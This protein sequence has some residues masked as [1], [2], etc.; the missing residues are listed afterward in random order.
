[1]IPAS[2]LWAIAGACVVKFLEGVIDFKK[3]GEETWSK[4]T[5]LVRR[6]RERDHL[7][8]YILAE[9]IET[10]ILLAIESAKSEV[11]AAER[12]IAETEL[13][14]ALVHFGIESQTAARHASRIADVILQSLAQARR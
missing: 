4:L 13:K 9:P 11:S 7:E 3:L 14:K 12:S 2:V 5:E 10:P 6:W 8:E 1:M